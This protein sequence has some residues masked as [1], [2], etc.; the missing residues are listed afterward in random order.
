MKFSIITVCLNCA[1]VLEKTI[2]S[3]LSQRNVEF[4][5]IIIDGNSSDGTKGIIAKYESQLGYWISESDNG[6]FDAMNKGIKKAAGEI[7]AFINSGDYYCKNILEK[8]QKYFDKNHIEAIGGSI[9][10]RVN[11]TFSTIIQTKYS[12]EKIPLHMIPHQAL[13]VRKS[14]FDKIGLFNTTYKLAA[15]YEWL[16]RMWK[17]KINVMAVSDFCADCDANGI[18]SRY[19]YDLSIEARQAALEV[20][21]NEDYVIKEQLEKYYSNKLEKVFYEQQYENVIINLEILA[22]KKCIEE[23]E[24]YIWGTGRAGMRCLQLME[25]LDICVKGFIDNYK[26]E[27]VKKIG[28]YNVYNPKEVNLNSNTKIC[29]AA[30]EFESQVEKQLLESGYSRNNYVLFSELLKSIVNYKI[31]KNG[32]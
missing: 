4:E 17:N 20:I 21:G 26:C 24:C 5:Y 29:I 1:D 22:L 27:I 18:T 23:S 32:N 30:R 6:V 10:F 2:N 16:L 9:H 14:V 8:I 25:K 31:E 13:F 19:P 12:L 15:D 11:D 7:I 28:M 3:V